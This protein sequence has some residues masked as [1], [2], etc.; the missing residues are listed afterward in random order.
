MCKSIMAMLAV[1]VV[2]LGLSKISSIWDLGRDCRTIIVLWA[3]RSG[4]NM[5]KSELT[6]VTNQVE[7][8]A[9]VSLK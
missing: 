3:C 9:Q 8:V 6:I 1:F 5:N 7:Y 4:S 2:L